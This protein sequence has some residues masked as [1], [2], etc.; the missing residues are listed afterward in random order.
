MPG[1]ILE[2]DHSRIISANLVEIGSAVSEEKIFFQFHPPPF[3]YF[4]LGGHLGRKSESPDTILEGGH[5]RTIPPK[6]GCN[7]P[8]G[9]SEEKI[10]M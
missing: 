6:F 2:G 1:T 8:S 9:F 3:F 10:F 4:Q 7:W 5:P